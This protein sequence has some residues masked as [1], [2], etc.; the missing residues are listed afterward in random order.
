MIHEYGLNNEKIVVLI[1]P[2][3]VMW[4]YFDFVI[5]LLKDNCHIIVPALP[6]YDE[7]HPKENFTSVEKIA[8]DIADIL[9]AKNIETIDVLYGCSMGGSIVLRMLVTRKIGIKNAILIVL[10]DFLMISM[11]KIGGLKL[12]EK[13]FSTDEYSKDDLKY[14]CKVLHF[15]SYKTI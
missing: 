9:I 13:A 7:E 10:R 15:I 6:G 3:C 8:D 4:N 2:S 12:L 11:G 14:I 1:H 5:A